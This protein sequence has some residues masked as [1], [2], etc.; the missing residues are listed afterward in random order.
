M[1]TGVDYFEGLCSYYDLETFDHSLSGLKRFW[2]PSTGLGSW[3][4]VRHLVQGALSI[5]T[6]GGYQTWDHV[7]I[8]LK[9]FPE[10]PV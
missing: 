6:D 4:H 8:G 10:I 9:D 3:L 5:S 1:H 2:V 7:G